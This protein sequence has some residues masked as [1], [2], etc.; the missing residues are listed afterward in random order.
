MGEVADASIL[1][2][3]LKSS[4]NALSNT[5]AAQIN[6][7]SPYSEKMSFSSLKHET[8]TVG[9][10][11]YTWK[12]LFLVGTIMLLAKQMMCT[13]CYTL[14]PSVKPLLL[15]SVH[16]D[17]KQIALIITTIPSI[18]NAI[19]C[20]ILST[21]SDRT[22][23]KYGRRIP[24]LIFSAPIL[25]LTLILISF[26]VEAAEV[27]TKLFPAIQCNWGLWYLAL[28]IFVFQVAFLFPGTAVYYLEAD[29]IPQKCFGQYMAL[30]SIVGT[31]VTSL[32][33]FFLLDFTVK[34][35]KL[36]FTAF[37]IAYVA[38]YLLQFF[39]I[40]EGEY[41][42]VDDK[43]TKEGSMARQTWE[44]CL[45]FFRQC[46][47]RKIYVFLALATGLNAASNV[48]RGMYN[49]LFVTKDLKIDLKTVGEIGGVSGIISAVSIYFF[50]KLMDKT[51]PM[52]I[53]FLGGLLVMVVNVFGFFFCWG[54]KT[55]YVIAVATTLMYAFQ[56]LANTPLLVKLL[57]TDKYGQYCSGNAIV[58]HI[59]LIIGSALGGIVT[60]HFGYRVMF[61]WDF[62]V[63]ALATGA[64]I[65]VYFEWKR[66]GG[67]N[68]Q[69][70]QVE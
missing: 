4:N 5:F 41:P 3:S 67:K 13:V 24:Y 62:F 54:V 16:A 6:L 60:Q 63:T 53:Y 21:M 30:G 29:V 18:L 33:N 28:M 43:V 22:R 44:Y 48:C 31:A 49:I 47:T 69:A 42:P 26:H 39:V 27:L 65:V 15:D 10:L 68:Y 32:F 50:G 52:F 45:M 35:L 9:T 56:N 7:I 23:T 14:V 64:L 25:A 36:S 37:G 51:H 8:W 12:Q 61:V 20:P 19:L 17:A 2:T 59:S 55:Y 38:V 57:P 34:N 40:K 66:Y 11:K 70:P 1:P 46:F 58:N